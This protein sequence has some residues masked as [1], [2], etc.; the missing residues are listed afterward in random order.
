M[1]GEKPKHPLSVE[2]Y[3]GSL[4]ELAKD[5]KDLRYDKVSELLGY[6]VEEFKGEADKDLADRK[7]RLASKLY[8]ASEYLADAREEIDSAWK[9]SKPY[10][11]EE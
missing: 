8:Q 3:S 6:L 5:I 2:R 11:K 4:E 9:I 7:T 1:S 10:M